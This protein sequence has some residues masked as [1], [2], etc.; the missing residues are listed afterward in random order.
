MTRSPFTKTLRQRPLDAVNPRRYASGTQAGDLRR[1]RRIDVLEIQEHYLA[2]DR[3]EL[4]YERVDLSER[5]LAVESRLFVDGI[6]KR[7][8]RFRVD[9]RGSVSLRA[10]HVRRG[11]VV[12][13]PVHPRPQ[14]TP[15]V[16]PGKA[17]P[18]RDVDLLEEISP[19]VGVRL[20]GAREALQ[21]AAVRVCEFGVQVARTLGGWAIHSGSRRRGDFL[22]GRAPAC[23]L[24]TLKPRA[25]SPEPRA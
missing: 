14:R 23:P 5:A 6:W 7:V 13:H 25:Q 4:P 9:E 18:Q 21:R 2:I 24:L 20:V 1:R 12:R 11:D 3:R 17:P 16:E 19:P 10:Y 8:D 15:A 22:T